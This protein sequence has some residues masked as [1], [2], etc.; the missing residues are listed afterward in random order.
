MVELLGFGVLGSGLGSGMC[1]F[2]V[3]RFQALIPNPKP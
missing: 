1:D 2:E 3:L